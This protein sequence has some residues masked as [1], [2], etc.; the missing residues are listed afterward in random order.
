MYNIAMSSTTKL[1]N[2]YHEELRKRPRGRTRSLS[3]D[4]VLDIR[5]DQGTLRAIADRWGLS[6]TAISAI[7]SGRLYGD[8][9]GPPAHVNPRGKP[10]EEQGPR[11]IAIV[12]GK[13]VYA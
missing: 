6:A 11:I 10:T 2:L 5:A 9:V 13:K 3:D 4:E 12:N 8:V 7:K 1:N